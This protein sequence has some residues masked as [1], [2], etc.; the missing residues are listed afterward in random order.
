MSCCLR[1][2]WCVS[3]TLL[4]GVWGIVSW[5][6]SKLELVWPVTYYDYLLVVVVFGFVVPVQVVVSK[7]KLKSK[8]RANSLSDTNTKKQNSCKRL[9]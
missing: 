6:W 8:E 2:V 1:F 9:K 7:L 5:S 3:D 4:V